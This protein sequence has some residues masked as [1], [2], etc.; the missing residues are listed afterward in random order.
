MGATKYQAIIVG[1]S[2]AGLAV[3]RE[4]S[5]EV[6]LLDRHDVGTNQTSACGTPLWVVEQ[7]GVKEGVIQ[8]QSTLGACAY[9]ILH[10]LR[11]GA[12]K[13]PGAWLGPVAELGNRPAI[14]RHWWPR[15]LAFGKTSPDL[16]R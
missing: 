15:Y 11:R 8:V 12:Q 16:G 6:L 4:L 9:R 7:L 5:G 3:A 14:R 2:V 1:A 10:T 13:M